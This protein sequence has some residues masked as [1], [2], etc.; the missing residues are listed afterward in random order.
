MWNKVFDPKRVLTVMPVISLLLFVLML[1]FSMSIYSGGTRADFNALGYTFSENY[2]SDLGRY[3]AINGQNNTSAMIVFIFAFFVLG[4]SFFIFFY[5][6]YYFIKGEY[7]INLNIFRLATF[8][9]LSATICIIGVAL[10]PSDVNFDDHVMFAEW[11]FRFF[12]AASILYAIS[13]FKIS[14][15]TKFLGL[16]YLI[17]SI[18]TGTYILFSDFKLN[19]VLFSDTLIAD[20]LA[21]K[22]IVCSLVI[23]F[24]IIGYFNYQITK[25]EV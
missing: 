24:L 2:I 23:G 3:I 13:Y 5:K 21:Q 9:A 20:V 19:K 18:A 11:I 4:S 15:K 16:G 14:S 6:N 1:A 22:F 25:S 12:F 7:Q 8:F 10:T 17:L